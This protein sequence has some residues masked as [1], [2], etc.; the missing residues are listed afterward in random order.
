MSN[1][2]YVIAVIFI[3]FWAIG[4]FI[5]GAGPIIHLLVV[6]AIVIIMVKIIGRTKP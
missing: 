3:F 6:I 4:Y 5:Y 2:L 1:L